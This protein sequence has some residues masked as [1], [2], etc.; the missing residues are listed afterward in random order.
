MFI[1][2]ALL[3]SSLQL[4]IIAAL[5]I[6]PAGLAAGDWGWACGWI[7]LAAY[8]V[9]LYGSTVVLALWAPASLEARMQAPTSEAQ[10]RDD[11]IATTI[12]L[13]VLVG[14]FIFVPLDALVWQ[15]LG[16]PAEPVS[17][18]GLVASYFG[19]FFVVWTIFTNSFA[20][21]IVEDQSD[22]GQML[23][24][25]G[26]YE[27]VRHPMYLGMLV[28]LAGMG[29]WLQSLA[30]LPLIGVVVAAMALRIVVEERVLL[31]TLEGYRDY[32]ARCRT[33]LLPF[34]W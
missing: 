21:P 23:I 1:V 31:Q 19:Y 4:A 30:S 9:A 26:P 6:L 18:I 7:Y 33:R 12:L 2:K 3:A 22:E 20:K 16:V 34:V 15:I 25:S 10:P 27:M 24:D 28:M 14:Y 11:K 8:A 17:W 5:L 29:L 13:S 32:Q